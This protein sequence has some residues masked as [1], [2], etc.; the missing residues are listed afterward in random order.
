[1]N[2]K[3]WNNIRN[4]LFLESICED[5]CQPDGKNVVFHLR[6][7]RKLAAHEVILIKVSNIF[8][9]I[10]QERDPFGNLAIVLPD[11]EFATMKNVLEVIYRGTTSICGD[12][13][14]KNVFWVLKNVFGFKEEDLNIDTE[15]DLPG[16]GSSALPNESKNCL[17][18]YS[19]DEGCV[20]N[21]GGG[22]IVT[23]EFFRD[24]DENCGDNKNENSRENATV[25][26][27][28]A[29]QS[30]LTG[31]IK[32]E[33]SDNGDT[34]SNLES[35]SK[36]NRWIC[37][38]DC[39]GSLKVGRMFRSWK[40]CNDAIKDT[41]NQA[42]VKVACSTVVRRKDKTSDN[43]ED[44]PYISAQ[45]KCKKSRSSRPDL[46]CPFVITAR[47]LKDVKRMLISKI[48]NIH[49]GHKGSTKTTP[50]V[51]QA[52][53]AIGDDFD[54]VDY[55]GRLVKGAKFATYKDFLKVFQKYCYENTIYYRAKT[56]QKM[57]PSFGL[58]PE[59]FPVKRQFI[60]CRHFGSPSEAKSSGKGLRSTPN[61]KT[62]CPFSL[63][64]TYHKRKG[65]YQIVELCLDHKG[66]QLKPQFYVKAGGKVQKPFALS[67]FPALNALQA[68]SPH[69]EELLA[70]R[71]NRGKVR[72]T[73]ELKITN[74]F[75]VQNASN[76]DES[77]R[78]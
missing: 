50:E 2:P 55:H 18:S 70:G 69:K 14:L 66:H 73:H 75:N 71:V 44:F 26:D 64:L 78:P 77:V 45:F 58:D 32:G 47:Y 8:R 56:S 17:D 33:P 68:E 23:D 43:T 49:R 39:L 67:A 24:M 63:K 61:F 76:L 16:A 15:V 37:G 35:R 29:T 27:V 48:T 19:E 30:D 31:H 4:A 51:V 74:L 52:V 28:N 6:G 62:G 38:E 41:C 11:L 1:M 9:L 36:L 34:G 42:G 25:T 57:N 54:R 65:R 72:E 59:M 12:K 13:E 10:A 3:H 40:D 22:M 5:N 20:N 60:I 7:G 53:P 46:I 21:N